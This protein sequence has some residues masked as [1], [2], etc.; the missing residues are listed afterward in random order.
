MV[1]G[2]GSIDSKHQHSAAGARTWNSGVETIISLNARGSFVMYGVRTCSSRAARLFPALVHDEAVCVASFAM[3]LERNDAI[4]RQRQLACPG[5]GG[6]GIFMLVLANSK[7]Y[8]QREWSCRVLQLGSEHGI[9]DETSS[10]GALCSSSL[11]ASAVPVSR[12]VVR[13]DSTAGQPS[14]MRLAP[15]VAFASAIAGKPEIRDRHGLVELGH[16]TEGPAAQRRCRSA[17][18]ALMVV[19]GVALAQ[20]ASAPEGTRGQ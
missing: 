6:L 3:Q 14:L 2:K 11:R 13:L 7:S 8:Q 1:D 16:G 19:G 9:N 12:K 10:C 5:E 4:L 20:T 17:P 15:A 18:R